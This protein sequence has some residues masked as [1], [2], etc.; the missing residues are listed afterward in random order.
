MTVHSHGI[1]LLHPLPVR[2]HVRSAFLYML[3]VCVYVRLY[4]Q[5][6]TLTLFLPS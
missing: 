3:F 4:E 2:L 1:V 5:V 6:Q